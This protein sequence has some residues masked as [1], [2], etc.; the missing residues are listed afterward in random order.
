[1]I[2]SIHYKLVENNS[3]GFL[4]AFLFFLTFWAGLAEDIDLLSN[5]KILYT[6]QT[7]Y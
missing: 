7:L 6:N 3:G 5:S 4:G 1:M 2:E